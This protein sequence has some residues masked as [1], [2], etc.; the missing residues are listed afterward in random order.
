MTS[1]IKSVIAST[2]RLWG[3]VLLVA[4]LVGSGFGLAGCG[5]CGSDSEESSDDEQAQQD[6]QDEQ[7]PEEE[8]AE[9]RREAYGLPF[10]PSVL[11]IR[12]RQQKVLVE[13]DMSLDQLEAFFEARL[14]DY[15]LIEPR[16]QLRAV[17]LRD[18]MPQ[19]Y[20][21]ASGRRRTTVVYLPA[22]DAPEEADDDTAQAANDPSSDNA[23][24]R[25]TSKRPSNFTPPSQRRKG[26][27]VTDLTDD[28]QPL[29]PGA[30][31]GEPYTP[32]KGSPLHQKRFESNFGKNYGEWTLH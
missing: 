18:Y 7:A 22:A 12:D 28:G 2:A 6:S 17:G 3:G 23:K 11:S 30:R 14:T 1:S 4:L 19:L 9:V 20:A 26:E 32:P 8:R 5:G 10:P 27:P 25:T 29:A 16:H 24:K 21:Y 31:W 13:T 15:E